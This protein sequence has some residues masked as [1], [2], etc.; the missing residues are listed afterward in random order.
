MLLAALALA[1]TSSDPGADALQASFAGWHIAVEDDLGAGDSPVRSVATQ[2]CVTT[3]AG[4]K[5]RW[6]VDWRTV[7]TI[8][9]EDVFVFLEAP[10]LK[11]AVVADVRDAAGQEKL[12]GMWTAMKTLATRCAARAPHAPDEAAVRL[13]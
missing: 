5:G 3:I 7:R 13:P 8:A 9:L 12:R 10:G 6:T 1:A 4:E 2:D 11:I